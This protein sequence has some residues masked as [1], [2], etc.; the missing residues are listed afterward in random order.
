[1]AEFRTKYILKYCNGSGVP[2]RVELQIKDYVGETFIIVNEDEYL[3]DEYN[4]YIT[5]NI[6]GEYDPDR[7]MNK[8][9]SSGNPFTLVYS[10][11]ESQKN[12]TIRATH[13]NMSFYEDMLFNIDDLAT[14]DETGIRCKFFYNNEIE[15][16]GFVTPDFFNVEIVSNP[17]IN[18]TASDRIGILKDISY[19]I[20][21]FYT[22]SR[23]NYA[24]II[25]KILKLTG[26]ELNINILADFYCDENDD[27]Q[28]AFL[29]T[30]VSELRFVKSEENQDTL[31]C[32][33]VLKSICDTF[34]CFFTQYKGEWWIV[35]KEQIE[36]GVGNVFKLDSEGEYIEDYEF[37][38]DESSFGIIDAGGERTL[39]PAGGKNTYI[40]NHGENTLYPKNRT[41]KG[42]VDEVKGWD[43]KPGDTDD[44]DLDVSVPIRYRDGGSW[45]EWFD[46]TRPWLTVGKTE[47]IVS[48]WTPGS[49]I[50]PPG[51]SAQGDY[52]LES[53]KFDI[54][55]QRSD[56]INF[57]LTIKAVGKPWTMA[58]VMV[59][60][61]FDDPVYKYAF[62]REERDSNNEGLTG[63]VDFIFN[64]FNGDT[65][66]TNISSGTNNNLIGVWFENEYRN[67]NIAVQLEKTVSLKAAAG[68]HQG[69][70]DLR[71]AK[72]FVRIY[73]N[74]WYRP[75][76]DETMDVFNK[77]KEITIDFKSDDETPKGTVYQS[78]LLDNFTK[79]TK[80]REVL[81]GDYQTF[82][83]NGYLYAGREDSR[84]IQYSESGERTENWTTILSDSKEPLLVHVLRQHTKTYARSHDELRIGFFTDR[85]NVLSKLALKCI[86]R[87]VHL[88]N[89][90]EDHINTNDNKHILVNSSRYFDRK[91]FIFVEGEIDYYRQHFKGI[92]AQ[93][94]NLETDTDEYIYSY[95]DKED[96]K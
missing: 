86:S 67:D 27:N 45:L 51:T 96:I 75:D 29:D 76:I 32:Y 77:I 22:D 71:N 10:N 46:D 7:D 44:I 81:T 63:N 28:N 4:N 39:I 19:P 34:N 58:R 53:D 18:L 82:G 88:V 1:M 3:K 8:I 25:S 55:V 79:P 2:L 50:D 38:Q 95:F 21:D 57:D 54:P 59:V 83:Q 90:D 91:R 93:T 12:G 41:L 24:G 74:K 36:E 61:E 69:N 47:K 30:Y 72:M 94:V 23:V 65:D 9:V 42:N 73:P 37:L 6:D 17:I 80:E 49:I 66:Y 26:L 60:L 5:A 43:R 14:S 15:W 87:R 16:I 56:S 48:T 62:L 92:L 40:Y 52:I 84:S 64:K 70:L 13:S 85:I 31:D 89:E 35:N 68:E 20:T 78:F 33:T 11:D